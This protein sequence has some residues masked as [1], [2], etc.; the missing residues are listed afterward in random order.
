MPL[1]GVQF[2]DVRTEILTNA[3]GPD[4]E[5]EPEPVHP[6]HPEQPD[7]DPKS[8]SESVSEMRKFRGVGG[9]HFLDISNASSFWAKS[10]VNC[11][12]VNL[13]HDLHLSLSH[14][15]H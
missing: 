5:L 15:W 13:N 4:P 3:V 1:T 11:W 7:P 6:K 10:Y 2:M 14:A 9:G 8:D 12:H